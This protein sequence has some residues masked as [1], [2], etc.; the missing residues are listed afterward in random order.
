MNLSVKKYTL[1]M[2]LDSYVSLNKGTYDTPLR[3]LLQ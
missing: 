2:L 1:I 3:I